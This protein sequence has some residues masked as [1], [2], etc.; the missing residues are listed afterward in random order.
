MAKAPAKKIE[1]TIGDPVEFLYG[2]HA[3]LVEWCDE[4]A[5]L[6]E[7]PTT[8]DAPRVAATLLEFLEVTLPRHISD[9]EDE[10]FPRLKKRAPFDE[11][12]MHVIEQLQTEHRED[13][14]HVEALRDSL[15]RLSFGRAIPDLALFA[16][17]VRVFTMLQRRHQNLENNVVLPAAFEYLDT[18]DRE[19][20]ARSML[21][22]RATV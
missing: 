13:V 4:L 22:R 17:F 14:E 15:H 11:R 2:E 16:A 18:E 12:L 5:R 7:D 10:L 9:E 19:A 8:D 20:L 21:S 3:D 6:S 1:D